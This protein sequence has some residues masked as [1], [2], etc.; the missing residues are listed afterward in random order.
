MARFSAHANVTM[1][2]I[3]KTCVIT[4]INTVAMAMLPTIVVGADVV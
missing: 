4:I 1:H 2:A 3:G